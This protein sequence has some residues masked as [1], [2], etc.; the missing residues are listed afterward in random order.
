MHNLLE[1]S[2][3]SSQFVWFSSLFLSSNML[4][5]V[6]LNYHVVGADEVIP[7]K[8]VDGV[9]V[10][11]RVKVLC[12]QEVTGDFNDSVPD[13]EGLENIIS[14]VD[15]YGNGFNYKTYCRSCLVQ[16]SFLTAV[17]SV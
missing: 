10:R 7:E 11:S 5:P 16:A 3:C 6:E 4:R 15:Y 1:Q 8:H 12:G 13:F 17:S 2:E 9:R 14:A